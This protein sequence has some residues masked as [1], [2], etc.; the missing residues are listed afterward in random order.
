[1]LLYEL[2]SGASP[3]TVEGED[4]SQIKVSRY[5]VFLPVFDC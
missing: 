2:L 5:V 3:F 1:M 4:N